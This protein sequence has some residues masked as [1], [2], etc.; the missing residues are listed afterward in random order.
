LIESGGYGRIFA[1]PGRAGQACNAQYP[2][3]DLCHR[4]LGRRKI[5]LQEARERPVAIGPRSQAP[6]QKASC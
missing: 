5:G 3:V 4:P 2:T 1:L 6:M